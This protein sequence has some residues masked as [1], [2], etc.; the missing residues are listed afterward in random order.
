MLPMLSAGRYLANHSTTSSGIAD[1]IGYKDHT[2]TL[3]GQTML[4]WS[5]SQILSAEN[6]KPCK[7]NTKCL[8]KQP[9]TKSALERMS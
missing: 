5:M 9:I 2:I 1:V 8:W 3:I 6:A 7:V 4:D